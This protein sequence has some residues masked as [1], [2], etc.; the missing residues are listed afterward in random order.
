MPSNSADIS[1]QFCKCI[2]Q[3]LSTVTAPEMEILP[4]SSWEGA[5]APRAGA[6]HSSACRSKCMKKRMNERE[7]D[8]RIQELKRNQNAG[9]QYLTKT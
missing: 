5:G 9:Q 6:Q 1:L 3:N 2:H 7:M 8:P 4:P